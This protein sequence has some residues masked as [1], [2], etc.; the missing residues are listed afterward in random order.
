MRLIL[1]A[2]ISWLLGLVTHLAP[3]YLVYREPFSTE[4]L[5]GIGTISFVASVIFF[6]LIQTPG[7][8]W[9][10]RRLGGCQRAKLFPLASLVLTLPVVLFIGLRIGESV[11]PGEAVLFIC[12]FLVMGPCFGIGFV[13]HCRKRAT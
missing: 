1:V 6:F 9:L 13:W 8:L 10:K 4:D 7:L 5:F 2:L 11:S 12:Q 3:T